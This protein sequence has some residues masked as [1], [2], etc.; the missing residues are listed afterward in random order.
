LFEATVKDFTSGEPVVV[1]PVAA[2]SAT[3][4][5][6][7]EEHVTIPLDAITLA[8]VP[9]EEVV[10][11]VVLIPKVKVSC[12]LGYCSDVYKDPNGLMDDPTYNPPA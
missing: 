6:L 5:E 8:P 3:Q 2:K 10:H 1:I 4:V 11:N 9:I 7:L 12:E